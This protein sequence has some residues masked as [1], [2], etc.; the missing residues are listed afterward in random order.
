MKP[1]SIVW[2]LSGLI[3]EQNYV[4]LMLAPQKYGEFYCPGRIRLPI[5]A[6]SEA[7]AMELSSKLATP[8]VE[9]QSLMSFRLVPPGGGYKKIN[10]QT[11]KVIEYCR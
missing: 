10:I 11:T 6:A 8:S 7:K 2:A 3:M 5:A 1:K 4:W 9:Y